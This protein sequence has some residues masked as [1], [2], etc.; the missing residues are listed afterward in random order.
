MGE[1]YGEG[2]ASFDLDCLGDGPPILGL[3]LRRA[4][5]LLVAPDNYFALTLGVIEIR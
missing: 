2:N 1:S 5:I 3:G 4:I